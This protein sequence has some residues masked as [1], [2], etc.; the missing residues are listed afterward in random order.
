MTKFSLKQQKKCDSTWKKCNLVHMK[1][2]SE[3]DS[4]KTREQ[5]YG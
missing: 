3:I 1:K 5:H 4:E 2:D